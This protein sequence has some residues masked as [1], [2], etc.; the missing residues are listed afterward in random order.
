MNFTLTA[1]DF[2]LNFQCTNFQ[3]QISLT[4]VSIFM[5]CIGNGWCYRFTAMPLSHRVCTV[6]LTGE[7]SV[8]RGTGLDK[9]LPHFTVTAE[10]YYIVQTAC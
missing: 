1:P 4:Q 7:T 6:S 5:Q 8:T 10:A 2:A 3:I 9:S